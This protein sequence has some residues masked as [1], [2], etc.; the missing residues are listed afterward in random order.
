VD[1]DYVLHVSDGVASERVLLESEVEDEDWFAPAEATADELDGGLD[2]DADE[3]VA[4][5]VAE[6]LRSLGE[7]W[8]ICSEHHRLMGMCEGWWYCEGEPYHD[9]AVVGSLA[10]SPT[11][12]SAP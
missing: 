7:V 10:A 12:L 5:E 8:P 11:D 9:V 6:V 2:A 1:A 4:S 3:L